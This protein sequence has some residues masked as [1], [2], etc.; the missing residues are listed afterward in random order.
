MIGCVITTH[1]SSIRPTGH[2][3]LLR[4]I[5][6]LVSS[7]GE[8][9]VDIMIIDNG[10]V[11]PYENRE[12]YDF[13]YR[14]DQINGLTGAWNVG[15]FMAYE[16]GHDIICVISDDVYFNPSF[17]HYE[18]I[19]RGRDDKDDTVFGIM[20][21]SKTAFPKQQAKE[22]Q[23]GKIINITGNKFAI[24]GWLFGFTRKFFENYS[25]NGMLFDNKYP[26]GKNE[27]YFQQRV[28]RDGGQS[29]L[30]GDCLA[31]HEHIGAW[32]KVDKI[33]WGKK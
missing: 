33:K 11:E 32:R 9:N 5:K 16:K 6:T 23:S 7:V 13:V 26:F 28:W 17:K 3:A 18:P 15:V 31:H 29:I 19:I 20:T 27:G 14:R 21:D 8:E 1:Q 24:H 10:S 12:K 25:T 2:Q 4:C 30:I 22:P